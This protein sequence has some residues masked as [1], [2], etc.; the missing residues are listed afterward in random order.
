[1]PR[2]SLGDPRS[3][4][5]DSPEEVMSASKADSTEDSGPGEMGISI[6][7][8]RVRFSARWSGYY[9]RLHHIV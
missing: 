4:E 9:T 1:V 6:V 2:G 8:L 3:H 7:N 5:V